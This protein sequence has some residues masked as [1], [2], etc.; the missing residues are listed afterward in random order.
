MISASLE[1][2]REQDLVSM[3]FGREDSREA[4]R[5]FAGWLRGRR[6]RCSKNDMSRFSYDLASGK[7]GVKLSRTNF[8]KT[9]LARFLDL[10]LV[11]EDL[12]YDREARKAVKAYGAVVQP[13]SRNR[14]MAPSLIYLARIIGERWNQEVF[15]TTESP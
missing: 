8:Y 1:R 2:V 15:G 5:A 6:G 12:V 7:T 4:A 11:T 3:P 10:G 9:V 14:P 13:G